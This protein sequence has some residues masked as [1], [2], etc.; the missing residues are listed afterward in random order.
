MAV[1]R[2]VRDLFERELA[3]RGIT[4]V[5]MT[6]ES[7][8]VLK[9]G[10]FTS[11]VTLD[12]IA[13]DFER[14]GD[15]GRI[16]R[17]VDTILSCSNPIPPWEQAVDRL[18]W[19]VE[20]MDTDVGDALAEQVSDQ[21]RVVLV[22]VSEDETQVVFL[23]PSVL[24]DWGQ[25]EAVVRQAAVQN[26][27]ALLRQLDVHIETVG[28]HRLGMFA[29]GDGFPGEAFKAALLL[30]PA[31]KEV[32]EPVLGWPIFAVM[33]NRDFVYMV[34]HADRDLLP[35]L[36]PVVVRE[37]HQS[38]YPIST[39]VFEVTDEGIRAIAEFQAPSGVDPVDAADGMKT[40]RYRGG[41]VCFR[42]P[43]S[44]EEEYEEE[45]GGTFFDE[46][47]PGELR[48]NVLTFKS[49]HPVDDDS[50][51][52][53]L[54]MRVEKVGGEVTKL[55]DGNAFIHYVNDGEDEGGDDVTVWYWE[56]AN[57]VPPEHLR[58]AV[59]SYT[60]LADNAED[61]EVVETLEMLRREIPRSTFAEELGS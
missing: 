41:V 21:I 4:V 18:R 3:A 54:E 10:E 34:P 39:E 50:P 32:V 22:C 23:T 11:T 14:D 30:C 9:V 37:Y 47:V 59:F 38:G 35:R 60:V 1:S 36:G 8:Y 51:V 12:N 45:G 53:V 33:P 42:L 13:R 25:S 27:E 46:D 20:S 56:V 55:P 15:E 61:P 52:D 57:A 24:E 29:S 48:L 43:S 17:F 6:E 31:L 16:S 7:N 49:S 2:R 44:W 58:L 19:T 40:I 5:E 26:M 28:E